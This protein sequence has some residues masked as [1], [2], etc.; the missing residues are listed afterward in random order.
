[1]QCSEID[2]KTTWQPNL[3]NLMLI[4]F[5]YAGIRV[6]VYRWCSPNDGLGYDTLCAGHSDMS[7]VIKDSRK[8]D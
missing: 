5:A 2:W 8:S 4:S 7:T 1:M 3:V 6:D